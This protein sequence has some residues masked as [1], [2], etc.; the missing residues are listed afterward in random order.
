MGAHAQALPS[1]TNAQTGSP[2][3]TPTAGSPAADPKTTPQTS[4]PQATLSVDA[5][6]VTL[7][8]TVRD[9]KGK[10]ISGLTKEDFSLT[11][12]GRPET[13]KYLNL[14]TNLP[15]TL[16]LLVDTSGSMRDALDRERSASKSFLDQMLTA[17]TARPP[18]KAFLLHFDS[19][20]EL[21]E[22]LTSS[23]DTRAPGLDQRLG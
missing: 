12:D 20:V 7:P 18:D 21:L 10:I 4:G 5:R 8:V 23:K 13:I 17:P 16:G 11:E 22:D 2:K 15:L 9:K 19:E 14:D 3:G 1:P 6:L